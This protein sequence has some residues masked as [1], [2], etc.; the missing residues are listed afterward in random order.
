MRLQQMQNDDYG[1]GGPSRT[2]LHVWSLKSSK[3]EPPNIEP[4]ECPDPTRQDLDLT[5]GESTGLAGAAHT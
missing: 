3:F 4:A 2:T 5:S 1:G